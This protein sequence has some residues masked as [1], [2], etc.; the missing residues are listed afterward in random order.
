[1]DRLE[2]SL[3]LHFSTLTA[4]GGLMMASGEVGLTLPLI[5]VIAAVA[6]FL[7]VDLWK[8]FYLPTPAAYVGMGLVA[9]YCMGDFLWLQNENQ[10]TA[11]AQL[12]VWVEAV[13]LFQRKSA[14]VFEQIGIFC[15][16]ELVV[17]AVF[18]HALG[19]GLLLIPFSII[20]IRALVL[21]HAF[22]VAQAG[23]E[24]VQ[25]VI[26]TNARD[27]GQAS[28]AQALRLPLWVVIAL[29]PAALSIAGV[30]FYALPRVAGA[31]DSRGVGGR[32]TTGFSRTM[33]LD[34]VGEL[35]QNQ[36]LVMR[37]TMEDQR[38]GRPYR[39]S[40]PIYLRGEVLEHYQ[41][42]S[43]V[44]V[45]SAA[46]LFPVRS[47]YPLPK[48]Y[49]PAGAESQQLYDRVEV[50]VDVQPLTTDALFAIVPYHQAS[51]DPG[52]G[53]GRSERLV[54]RKGRWL[55]ARGDSL[56]GWT[57]E[58]MEYRF[59]THAFQHGR[60]T[61]FLRLKEY[62]ELA[63]GSAA[64][65]SSK[66]SWRRFAGAD[67]RLSERM[68]EF[69]PSRMPT[70]V[71]E[72]EAVVDSIGDRAASPY[73][74]GL[75]IE[76][77]LASSGDF[78]Y[79][80]D[81]SE[82]RDL[83]VD[84]IEG[85]VANSRR[86]HCQYFASAMV[87]MLRSQN[88]PARIVLGYKTDEYN[89]L[90]GH[91]VVRQLHAH[92]WVEALMDEEDLPPGMVIAGQPPLGPVLVRFDPTPMSRGPESP[93]SRPSHFYDFAQT[94]W[95]NYVLDMS[96]EQQ[97][98]ELFSQG[99]DSDMNSAYTDMLTRLKTLASRG[100]DEHLSQETLA[101]LR[102]FSWRAAFLSISIALIAVGLYWMGLPAWLPRIWPTHRAAAH[103]RSV[104]SVGFYQQLC[105]LLARLELHRAEGQTPM[106]FAAQA[107]DS[108]ASRFRPSP[109]PVRDPGEPAMAA[110]EPE[111]K[112]LQTPAEERP[113][114]DSPIQT[115][116]DLFY[117][118]RYGGASVSDSEAAEVIA[119]SLEQIEGLVHRSRHDS[120]ER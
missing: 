74:V 1:M 40:E 100:I 54:H 113:A 4:L 78:Q 75:A 77:H 96:S 116:V 37:L 104:S 8:L 102:R 36:D 72:S 38:T 61:R 85:F 33:T 79:T 119:P 60:Q 95:N 58:R 90:G 120:T 52:Q 45:W 62:D 80:L 117:R 86:G 70:I 9:I 114:G 2:R 22:T 14:R 31:P 65:E 28:A 81:L 32:V 56:G 29:G 23:A 73:Q 10:L 106:E 71:A 98:E 16:L 110:E 107:S 18:N 105:G 63:M 55:L 93:L 66:S 39:A 41:N 84:P 7:L 27:A 35:L 19:F 83:T 50:R 24:S 108:L 30:F 47:N 12:L 51:S 87:M 6:S 59:G 68:L 44:G 67:P 49:H 17:A 94:L 11:V 82:R 3:Q 88:I 89:A 92:A 64:A 103:V 48:P 34:Q 43:G 109:S 115:L 21:L 42:K 76:N 111:A 25:G 5:A 112:I 57:P 101:V 99:R 26:R 15:L 13:L 53:S 97:Q 20:G 69:S 91:Y 46:P 118:V